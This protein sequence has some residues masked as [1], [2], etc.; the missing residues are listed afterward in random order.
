MKSGIE[1]AKELVEKVDGKVKRIYWTNEEIDKYFAKR[2]YEQIINHGHTCF[3]NPCSDLT[4]VTS[5]LMKQEN[6]PHKWIMQLEEPT[7]NFNFPRMHFMLDFKYNN[8]SHVLNFI[9]NNDVY[10]S[11]EVLP[12]EKYLN[13]NNR[14]IIPSEKLDLE[15]SIYENLLHS[16]I[17][18]YFEEFSLEKVLTRLKRDNNPENFQ[19]FQQTFGNKFKVI[20]R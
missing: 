10:F 6:I 7:K 12:L 5:N 16:N 3:M 11:D 2:N 13:V 1:Y 14:V 8:E 18:H 15:K 17:S 9:R 20:E 4:L 19:M